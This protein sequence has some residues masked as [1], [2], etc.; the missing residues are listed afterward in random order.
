MQRKP[1]II[2]L[3]NNKKGYFHVQFYMDKFHFQRNCDI[4]LDSNT[5]MALRLFAQHIILLLCV[6]NFKNK[7]HK[8]LNLDIYIDIYM[9]VS[10]Y[11]KLFLRCFKK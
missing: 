10:V 6:Y 9:C 8:K 4:K 3:N 5:F 2:T 1:Q 7:E 11:S